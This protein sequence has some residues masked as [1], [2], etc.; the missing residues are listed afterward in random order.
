MNGLKVRDSAAF[1]KTL[2]TH[3]KS[4]LRLSL[5]RDQKP[6]TVTIPPSTTADQP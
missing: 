5:M 2:D 6:A 4:A 3:G 1:F